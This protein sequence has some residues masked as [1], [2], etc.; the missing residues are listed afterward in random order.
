LVRLFI[1][2]L[3]LISLWIPASAM[4]PSG[5]AA[6]YSSAVIL[7]DDFEDSNPGWSPSKRNGEPRIRPEDCRSTGLVYRRGECAPPEPRPPAPP[8][9]A[10]KSAPAKAKTAAQTPPLPVKKRDVKVAAR[11]LSE[12]ERAMQ[13]PRPLVVPASRL[14]AQA[15]AKAEPHQASAP[16]PGRMAGQLFI[17][18]FKGKGLGDPQVSR[19]AD[20]LRGGRLSGVLL[21]DANI[22]NARQLRQLISA[23]T[24]D[25][26]AA[27]PLVAIEQPG[28]P[29]T[30]LAEDKGF[31]YYA[32]ASATSSE[33][34]P[35]EAQLVYRDMAAELSTFGVNL[36]IGPSGDICRDGGVDLSATCFAP[37][38]SRVAAFAA[39]FNFGHHDRGVLTA[40]RHVPFSIG[41]QAPWKTERAS[42]AMLRRLTLAEPSDALVIRVKAT[43]PFPLTEIQAHP[44]HR[45]GAS[46]LRQSLGFNGAI[47][48]DLDL[49]VSGAPLRYADTIVRAFQ[50]GADIV[51]VRDPS[52]LP[53][54]LA[55]LGYD[56]M[57]A[58]VKSGRLQ[59][60][61][62]EDAYAHVQRLKDRLRRLQSRTRMA[63]IFGQ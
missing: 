33:R 26:A 2:P 56:A 17:S 8:K 21:N 18:G 55:V 44:A 30:A 35:Y 27:V 24:R 63:E 9:E 14:L 57:E 6:P 47:I 42:I 10:Q 22:S 43:G 28:G 13:A 52:A 51:M 49:G 34:E 61:R 46:K 31:S 19:I 48:Y 39:A 50:N 12:P 11:A 36:N 45:T 25:N 29:D 3:S 20:A 41:L 15:P 58:G 38:Q 59:L 7:V 5:G 37:W 53:A 32:S 60:A 16:P 40:L 4:P 23:L 54:D 1:I 62:I